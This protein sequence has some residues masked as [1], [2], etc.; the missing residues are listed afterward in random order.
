MIERVSRYMRLVLTPSNREVIP[1][2]LKGEARAMQAAHEVAARVDLER[3]EM[4]PIQ[5]HER[6]GFRPRVMKEPHTPSLWN[7]RRASVLA[8]PPLE[9]KWRAQAGADR[10]A[11]SPTSSGSCFFPVRRGPLGLQ[12][13]E[14]AL[15]EAP[16]E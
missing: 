4:L 3:V 12:T 8:R 16:G 6:R 10:P 14:R 15:E 9:S 2:Y 5:G 13:V 11:L 1:P 7:S